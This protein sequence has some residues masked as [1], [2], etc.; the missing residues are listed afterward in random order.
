MLT[1]TDIEK[2][3]IAEKQEGLLFLILGIVAILIA[4]ILLICIK[5][6]CWRGFA[7]PLIAIGL[8]QFIVGYSIYKRS[9]ADRIK[10]V[11]AYDLNP[12]EL[13]NKELPRMETV[14]K[15]FIVY[16]WVEIAFI[17]VGVFL[18]IKYK[19]NAVCQNSWSGNAFWYGL[20]IALTLQSI[21]MLGADFFA[22]KRAKTYTILLQQKIEK[23]FEK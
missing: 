20:G 6:N 22:E 1:K 9:D 14:N 16:R 18:I 13:K 4:A 8:I 5:N 15:N 2:Y 23:K 12:N 11:Y 21:A 10:V 7:I 3:F 17:L 19:A